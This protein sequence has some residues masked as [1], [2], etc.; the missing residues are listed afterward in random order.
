MVAHVLVANGRGVHGR[1]QRIQRE[2]FLSTI[3]KQG[4]R[5]MRLKKASETQSTKTLFQATLDQ[6]VLSI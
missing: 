3:H 4:R 2:W 1:E 5:Q 6:L